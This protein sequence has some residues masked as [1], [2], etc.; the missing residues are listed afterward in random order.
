MLCDSDS[1]FLY[2]P[3]FVFVVTLGNSAESLFLQVFRQFYEPL[4]TTDYTLNGVTSLLALV[5]G[6]QEIWLFSCTPRLST[7]TS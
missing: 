7:M 3:S 1:S 4:I 5:A 2:Q 6:Y